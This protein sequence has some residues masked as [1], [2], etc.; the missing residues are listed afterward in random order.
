MSHS[1]SFLMLLW[2]PRPSN[3]LC[4]LS[5]VQ[6]KVCLKHSFITVGFQL[7]RQNKNGLSLRT[8]AS[9]MTI[10]MHALQVRTG[11]LRA[12]DKLLEGVDSSGWYSSN[13]IALKSILPGCLYSCDLRQCTVCTEAWNVSPHIKVSKPPPLP[14]P[15][16][17]WNGILYTRVSWKGVQIQNALAGWVLS[18]WPQSNREREGELF[19][20][21]VAGGGVVQSTE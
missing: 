2:N 3:F 19:L 17:I 18:T 20:H 13:H 6:F 9:T 15:P 12:K 4:H 10:V 1:D 7:G 16:W 8:A 5:F 11:G 14:G 21:S